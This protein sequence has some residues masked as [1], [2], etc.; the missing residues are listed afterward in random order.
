MIRFFNSEIERLINDDI[1]YSDL[2]TDI[3]GISGKCASEFIARQDLVVCATEEA[4]QVFEFFDIDV[5]H[6]VPS[7]SVSKASDVLLSAYGD[8]KN[9]QSCYR[10]CSSLMEHACGLA[11]KTK[12][13]VD[14]ARRENPHIRVATTRKTFPFAKKITIKAILSGGASV[15]RLGLSE[16]IL[17][18]KEHI[19]FLGGFEALLSKID[20]IKRAAYDKVVCVETDNLDQA[21]KLA[22][23]GIEFLQ[24]DKFDIEKTKEAVAVLKA[25]NSSIKIAVAGGISDKNVCQYAK[26]GVDSI[27]TSWLYFAKPADIG[28]KFTKVD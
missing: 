26:V 13:F 11:T 25:I 21:V 5:K 19:M 18:F 8:F 3:L 20:E 22:K 7:G 1:P 10:I 9:I 23:S 4:K 6:I 12:N 14:L 17:I 15:H 28:V 27:V 2:T 24:L 16:T